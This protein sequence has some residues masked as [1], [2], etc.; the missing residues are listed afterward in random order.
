MTEGICW[1]IEN[2]GP[3]PQGRANLGGEVENGLDRSVVRSKEN[4]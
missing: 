2:D 1:N 3:A 4:L